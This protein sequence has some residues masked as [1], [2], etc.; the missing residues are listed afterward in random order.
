MSSEK[1]SISLE[2]YLKEIEGFPLLNAEAERDLASRIRSGD[3]L[4]REKLVMHNL[5]LVVK[6]AAHY[7]GK[8]LEMEE[9]QRASRARIR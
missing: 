6:M 8:G 2:L 7:R 1:D 9:Q 3:P 5:R 4:A